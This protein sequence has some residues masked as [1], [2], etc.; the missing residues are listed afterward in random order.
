MFHPSQKTLDLLE[1]IEKRIDPETE[2]DFQDQWKDFLYDRF[3]GELFRPK[4]KKLSLPTV[5]TPKININDAVADYDLML[6][7]QL[8]LVSRDLNSETAALGIRAN[9]GT[10]ILSSL[11]GAEI[12][13]MPY[14]NNTLPTTRI[15]GD[16]ER[17][18]E[19]AEGRIPDL[20]CGFGRQVFEFGE[21]CRELFSKYPKISKYVPVYHP[22]LQGPLDIAELLWG[23]EMF[24]AMYDEPELV[25]EA[26]S[27][28]T[29]T[30]TAFM[31]RWNKLFPPRT[32]MNTHWRSLY[33]RGTILIRNDSAMNLSPDF[34]REFSIPYDQR[35]LDRFGGGAIHF[36]G[37]G[38][39]YI[40]ALSELR[41]LYG[42]NMS[43]PHLN[44]M[45][46]IYQNTVDKGI[47]LLSFNRERAES[48]LDRPNAF[49]HNLHS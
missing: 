40:E 6:Q 44:D 13:I 46:K 39:H 7:D 47:K 16:T 33:Y 9:Y 31:E 20:E 3:K 36:C 17:I 26:L 10:G 27:L 5:P 14:E 25:H 18:R 48:D 24:Y 42:V 30:Y 34:Y 19:M 23:G 43:Q 32:D 35:L 38:D 45:E 49:H 11:F 22:D 12:F 15:L 37:R 28:I 21:I 2:E 29:D 8:G 41:G 4:R 1:D